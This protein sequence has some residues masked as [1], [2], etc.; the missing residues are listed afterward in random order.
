MKLI[1][2]TLFFLFII[3]FCSQKINTQTLIPYLGKN[4]LIGL[5]DESG[6]VVIDPQFTHLDN[7]VP[8]DRASFRTTKD[9]KKVV[10]LRNGMALPDPIGNLTAFWIYDFWKSTRTA[11]DTIRNLIAVAK[12]NEITYYNLDSEKQLIVPVDPTNG[13]RAWFPINEQRALGGRTY[14]KFRYGCSQIARPNEKMNFIDLSLNLIFKEDF[15]AGTVVD[16]EYF[17]VG[18]SDHKMAI[19]NRTGRIRTK[20]KWDMIVPSEKKG[21]FF[22]NVRISGAH[23]AEGKAGLINADGKTIIDGKY[24][25]IHPVGN[26]YIAVK[27]EVGEGLMDYQGKMLIEPA[28]G[29][30]TYAFDD[31]FIRKKTGES[32]L[33]NSLGE[34]QLPPFKVL[35]YMEKVAVHQPYF[36]FNTAETCGAIDLNLKTI[37]EDTCRNY[38]HWN[39]NDKTYFSTITKRNGKTLVGLVNYDGEEILPQQYKEIKHRNG[40]SVFDLKKDGLSGIADANGKFILPIEFEEVTASVSDEETLFYGRSKD[41]YI[42]KCFDKNGQR[43]LENDCLHPSAKDKS[44]YELFPR[45]RSPKRYALADGSVIEIPNSWGR[46]GKLKTGTSPDGIMILAEYPSHWQAF[47]ADRKPLFSE[48]YALPANRMTNLNLDVMEAYGI[49]PVWQTNPNARP[50]PQPNEVPDIQLQNV[51]SDPSPPIQDIVVEEVFIDE[52]APDFEDNNPVA[53]GVMNAKGEWVISP[54]QNTRLVPVSWNVV[55]EFNAYED[56]MK[57]R[58]KKIHLVNVPT[59][60]V[61]DIEHAFDWNAKKHNS[62]SAYKYVDDPGRPGK[63]TQLFSWFTKDGQQL[64]PFQFSMAPRHLKSRNLA[65]LHADDKTT[66]VIINEKTEVLAEL[67]GLDDR[68]GMSIKDGVIVAVKDEKWGLLDSL[69]KEILPYQ[70]QKLYVIEAGRFVGEAINPSTEHRLLD[71]QG[72]LIKESAYPIKSFKSGGGFLFI[73][74]SEKQGEKRQDKT[75]VFSPDGKQLAEVNGKYVKFDKMNG[76]EKY[77]QFI[78]GE[79]RFWMSL[80]NGKSFVEN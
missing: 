50:T 75:I 71:W 29:K 26:D 61:I 52:P 16:E 59:P 74:Y 49:I 51:D 67:P 12:K 7:F 13:Y 21:Y 77:A 44:S 40:T 47:N 37:F 4:N 54:K 48:G 68:G 65:R 46:F 35:T 55:I 31:Y 15:A 22:T 20:F 17:I 8:P 33:I 30:I 58:P 2:K 14:F 66:W 3:L 63:Q 53:C 78:D 27:T 11:K 64:C 60:K 62:F 10:V 70:F 56:Q 39:V 69:G 1:Y 45:G 42:F 18:N 25:N 57:A 43:I 32:T 41:K 5:A 9:G 28:E 34:E 73:S 6:K 38:Q 36:K 76:N 80:K 19:A 79:N 23:V 72:N 24:L